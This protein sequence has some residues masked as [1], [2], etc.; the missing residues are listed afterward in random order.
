MQ[1]TSETTVGSVA[2]AVPASTRLFEKLGIDYCCGGQ[3]TLAQA[4]QAASVEVAPVL[5]EVEQVANSKAPEQRQEFAS[6]SGLIAHINATHHVFVRTESPRLE[7][8]AAKVAAKHGQNHT[9]VL[10]VQQIFGALA[11]ELAPHL[12]KEEQ[13]LFPYL[14]HMEEC[15]LAGEPVPPAMFGPIENPINMMTREHGGAGAALRELREVTS[16]YALP[17][18]ACASYRALYD[19]LAGFERDLHQHIHLEN[20]VLFPRAIKMAATRAR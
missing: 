19:G 13:I 10:R 7:A 16:N 18:D 5:A 3:R 11:A 4:C 2:Q 8:L 6:L 20:N 9:E 1:I 17:A 14:E 15:V 12:M